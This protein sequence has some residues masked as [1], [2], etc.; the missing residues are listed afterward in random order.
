MRL[1]LSLLL[2][3]AVL[4]S[5]GRRA[6]EPRP[7]AQPATAAAGSLVTYPR[8]G[9]ADPHEWEG[10]APGSYPVHG[11]DISR[12]QGDIDWRTARASGV[13]F[14]FIKATEGGDLADPMFENHRR[15]ARSAGV[16]W[17]AYH[18][19]YFCRPADVQARWFIRH[20]PKGSDLPHVLDMEWNP[21][22]RTCRKRPDGATVRA[23]A[24]RFLDILERHYGRRPIVYTTVDFYQE[25]GIGRLRG[26]EFWL[27]SVAGHPRE[28]YPGAPWTFWQYT[29]TGLVPGISGRVDINVFRGGPESW[30]RWVSGVPA[31]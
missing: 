14:A 6:P 31:P 19:F 22:S 21:R 27:R 26:T 17:G 13:S 5:C 24:R 30:S 28:V 25:T 23:E 2:M 7:T 4:V 10:R 3:M 29:G 12:W 11:I 9:D 20:V 16:P 8:F 18:Y 1:V 15:G